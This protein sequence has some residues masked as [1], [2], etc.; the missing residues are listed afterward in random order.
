MSHGVSVFLFL[1]YELTPSRLILIKLMSDESSRIL[2][3]ETKINLQS[4]M[5]SLCLECGLCNDA[6]QLLRGRPSQH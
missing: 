6:W 3:I 5:V 4:I 1:R 2:V